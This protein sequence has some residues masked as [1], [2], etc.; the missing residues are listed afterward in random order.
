M[1]VA[2]LMTGCGLDAMPELTDEE[3]AIITEYAAGLLLKYSPNYD[4][5]IV[6]DVEALASEEQTEEESEVVESSEPES[7]TEAETLAEAGEVNET[8]HEAESEKV[9]TDTSTVS[10][11]SDLSTAL[12]LNDENVSIIYSSYEICDSYPETSTGFSVSASQGG[13]LLVVHFDLKNEADE[14]RQVNLMDYN[15]SAVATINGER[16]SKALNTL[17][18]NDMISYYNNMKSAEVDDVVAL[19]QVNGDLA[20]NLEKISLKI[21]SGGNVA[22]ID[23][24]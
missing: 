20:E 14:D 6:D 19:F 8:I 21:S 17:L 2:L 22:V 10:L 12:G 5:K 24:E 9:D 16:S 13:K 4:Y 18:P 15:V 1:V 23:I 7:S 11:E 3:S